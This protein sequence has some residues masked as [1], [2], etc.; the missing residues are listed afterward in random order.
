LATIKQANEGNKE[1]Q[2][3]LRQ[4]NELRAENGLPTVQEELAEM[5]K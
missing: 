1:Q 3:V 4:E 2:E 5:G